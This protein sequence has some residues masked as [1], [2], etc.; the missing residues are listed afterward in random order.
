MLI[1]ILGSVFI[2]LLYELVQQRSCPAHLSQTI[3]GHNDAF[4]HHHTL[5][6]V[7]AAALITV[8]LPTVLLLDHGLNIQQLVDSQHHWV[9]LSGNHYARSG[10]GS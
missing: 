5:F 7:A 8:L 3:A 1:G 10:S 4:K 6:T 9:S 2:V